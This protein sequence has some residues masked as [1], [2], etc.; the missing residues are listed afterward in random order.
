MTNSGHLTYKDPEAARNY[1]H[2]FRYGYEL[3]GRISKKDPIF[4]DTGSRDYPRNLQDNIA[5]YVREYGKEIN[6]LQ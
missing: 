1:H 2:T 4:K 5:R 3:Y 6:D